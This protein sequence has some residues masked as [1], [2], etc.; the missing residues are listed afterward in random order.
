MS[1]ELSGLWPPVSTAF[2]ADGALDA[3]RTVAHSKRL[4]AD[5]AHGLAILGTTS[6]A[7]S[8]TLDERRR[9]IDAH[10]E[11]GI[12]G[13]QLLPGTG[14]CAID[15]AVALTRR[16]GEVGASGVLLLPPFYYKKVSDEGIF[17]FVAQLIERVGAKMPK[18][19][20]YH[21][22][23]IAVVGWSV[24][25][26]QRL[27]EAFPEVIMGIKDSSGDFDVTKNFIEGLPGLSIF[28]GAE[29]NFLRLLK[30]GAAGCISATANVNAAAIRKLFDTWQKPEAE[31]LQEQLREVR[32]AVEKHT[33]MPALKVILA[34]RYRHADWKVIRA[35]LMQIP[36]AA[37]KELLAE[38]AIGKLLEPV[39]A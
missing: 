28:P 29:V 15:D 22:P 19:M 25:L 30:L 14:A 2:H 11:A 8:L 34:E 3:A 17:R 26:V 16:A 37:Q 35:P 38:P 12:E 31:A 10:V 27:R 13:R 23:P 6:E 18:L 39:A 33:M 4:L 9:V 21:I 20:L 36:D 7:N 5:G 32:K 24:P 1:F